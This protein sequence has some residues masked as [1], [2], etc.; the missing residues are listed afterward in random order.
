MEELFIVGWA[1]YDSDYPTINLQE[2]DSL[3][4]QNLIFNEIKKEN[5][6]FGGDS[7]QE[8]LLGCPVFS[9]G[10]IFR[11]SMRVWGMIM[12]IAHSNIDEI[13]MP[14]Y[15]N[16]YMNM[17]NEKFSRN[18]ATVEINKEEVD[19]GALP[20]LCQQDMQIISE[21]LYL[22]TEFVTNDKALKTIYPL[23]KMRYESL[24]E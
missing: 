15:M 5:L 9:N 8:N 1:S 23:F 19:N 3:M 14:N 7:H 4:V 6:V 21:C 10:T 20:S 13:G 2:I 18:E 22:E 11:A 16:Y 17:S 12:A 24:K